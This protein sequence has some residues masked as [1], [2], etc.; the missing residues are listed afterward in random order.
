MTKLTSQY[1]QSIVT[2]FKDDILVSDSYS[3][4]RIAS[5]DEDFHYIIFKDLISSATGLFRNIDERIITQE[6]EDSFVK[7]N[8]I[9]DKYF[10]FKMRSKNSLTLYENSFLKK[11]ESFMDKVELLEAEEFEL[12]E[13]NKQEDALY[14]KIQ[15]PNEENIKYL[16][17]RH[18][19]VL[20]KRD[21]LDKSIKE[22][23][24][25][26]NNFYD[27]HKGAFFDIFEEIKSSIE[28]KFFQILDTYAY[29]YNKEMF[30]RA[31]SSKLIENFL[32]RSG[33][34]GELNICKFLEYYSKNIVTKIVVDDA[35]KMRINGAKEYCFKH[36][37]DRHLAQSS[38]A[39]TTPTKVILQKKLRLFLDINEKNLENS[40]ESAIFKKYRSGDFIVVEDTNFSHLLLLISGEVRLFSRD[41]EKY[42]GAN[43][44]VVD[45]YAVF[46]SAVPYSAQCVSQDVVCLNFTI[47]TEKLTSVSFGKFFKNL[48]YHLLINNSMWK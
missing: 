30:S 39:S 9:Y 17:T 1:K 4:E 10:N 33:V 28:S 11:Q 43:E 29:E 21:I 38:V 32:L 42:I 25:Y 2:Y 31:K 45:A 27:Y 13:L 5:A 24:K 46:N 14:K 12:I 35:L 16:R 44:F 22:L 41:I 6:L 48:A 3:F 7:L 18:A 23:V 19:D 15:N 8:S 47:N 34:R 20:D 36:A 40:I 26:V 37:S